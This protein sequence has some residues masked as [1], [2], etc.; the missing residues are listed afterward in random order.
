MILAGVVVWAVGAAA[1]FR[2]GIVPPMIDSVI[3]AAA[4]LMILA[5]YRFGI[6]DREKRALRRA[7]SYCLPETVIDRMLRQ[8]AT[9]RLGGERRDVTVM[10]SDVASFTALSEDMSP[11]DVVRLMNRYLS[12]MTEVIEAHGGFVDKYIG[13]AIVAVFGTPLDDPEHALH[14][15]AAALARTSHQ[16]RAV[17]APGGVD[18]PGEGRKA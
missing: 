9:P 11:E 13:D 4:S 8:G 7:F 3:A 12:A 16:D 1:I 15:V 5:G 17:I 2:A 6:T 14:A 10:F 18:P